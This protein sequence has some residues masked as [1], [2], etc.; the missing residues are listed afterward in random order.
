MKW[1]PYTQKPPI[2]R[3][4]NQS[5]VFIARHRTQGLLIFVQ[6][7]DYKDGDGFYWYTSSSALTDENGRLM[8]LMDNDE[9]ITWEFD[10][11]ALTLPSTLN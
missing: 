11:C 5:A 4:E 3:G 7:I 2:K 8:G 6:Y 1:K 9:P 10:Y